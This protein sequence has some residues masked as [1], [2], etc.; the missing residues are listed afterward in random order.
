MTLLYEADLKAVDPSVVLSGLPVPPDA[1]TARLVEGTARDR[2]EL[3]ALLTGH[4]KEH[5]FTTYPGAGHAFFAVDRPSYRP[6]AA[7]DGWG[8]IF[9]FLGRTL[10]G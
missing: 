2:A 8:R 4:G 7:V 6:E 3:D 1:Y 5:D 10:E 9:A